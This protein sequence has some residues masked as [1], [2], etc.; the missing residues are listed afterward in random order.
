MAKTSIVYW[1]PFTIPQ[2]VPERI[3]WNQEPQPFLADLRERQKDS[4]LDSHFMCPSVKQKHKNTFIADFTYDVDVYSYKN[5]IVTKTPYVNQR[6]GVYPDSF[7][8]DI[9]GFDRVFFSEESLLMQTSPAYYHQTSYSHLGHVPSGQF[10]IS[11]WFRP[12]APTVQCFSHVGKF[13][14]KEGEPLMYFNFVTNDKVELK[15]FLLT[16]T[17]YDISQACISL[18]FKNRKL[19]LNEMYA[20]F[21]RSNLKNT[22]MREIKKNLL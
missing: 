19:P 15:P 20:R 5:E 7:A 1:S 11:Q 18:K 12:S 6:V 8:F 17:L 13:E 22:I 4:L 2:N 10:D 3:L 21:T 9:T 16:Q 14:A